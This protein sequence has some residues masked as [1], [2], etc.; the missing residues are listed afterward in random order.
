M[1]LLKAAV[2]GAPSVTPRDGVYA[3]TEVDRIV[4]P[5]ANNPKPDYPRRLQRE[6]VETSFIAQFVVDS[7]GR[8][9]ESSLNFPS[10]VHQLFIEAV[11]ESLR[12]ARF[13]PAEV[14]GRRVS[15]FV[16]QQF[17]FV[18]ITGRSD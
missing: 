1:D 18:L 4:M 2:G 15:Q 13:Y 17:S 8:V 11:R 16:E 9:D 7:T 3:T 14:G 12:R 5:F 10:N 6:G